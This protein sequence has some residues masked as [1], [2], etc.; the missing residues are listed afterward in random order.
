MR[1]TMVLLVIT[2]ACASVACEG[3]RMTCSGKSGCYDPDR[4]T[5]APSWQPPDSSG[6]NRGQ[7]DPRKS[8]K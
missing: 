7:R 5:N 4:N 3:A 2:V 8:A 6:A 1:T